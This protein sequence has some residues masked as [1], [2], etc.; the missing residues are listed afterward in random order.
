MSPL[1]EGDHRHGFKLLH[2]ALPRIMEEPENAALRIDLC[3][4]AFLQLDPHRGSSPAG[5]EPQEQAPL[6]VAHLFQGF[7]EILHARRVGWQLKARG[8]AN[9]RD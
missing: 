6:L 3:A 9:H 4:A 2:E 8:V 5:H 1:V 7:P